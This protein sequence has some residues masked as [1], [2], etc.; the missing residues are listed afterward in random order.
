MNQ[1]TKQRIVG[2]IVLLALALIFLPIIFDGQGSYQRPVSSRIP[3]TPVINLLPE[4]VAQRVI[5]ETE[6]APTVIP[7][8]DT[9]ETVVEPVQEP[10]GTDTAAVVEPVTIADLIANVTDEPAAETT[11]ASGPALDERGLPIGWSVRLASFSEMRNAESL[12]QRLLTSNYK[13]YTREVTTEQGVMTAVYVGP[14]LERE[15]IEELR[16]QLQG[17]FQLSGM[18]VRFEIEAL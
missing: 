11:V 9:V 12:L 3:Q 17:E 14:Q 2:T 7:D 13:A 15:K 1:N 5:L 4:P 18:V 8:T 16:Q 10:A 6:P